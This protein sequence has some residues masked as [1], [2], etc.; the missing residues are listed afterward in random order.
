VSAQSVDNFWQTLRE[1]W[2]Q[3]EYLRLGG[4]VRANLRLNAIRGAARRQPPLNYQLGAGVNFDLLGIQAPFS[5]ALAN[6]NSVYRL[7]RYSFYGVSPAYQWITLHAGDRHL[8]FSPYSLAGINFRGVGFELRPGKFYIGG[9]S[10][11]LRRARFQE[12]GSIQRLETQYQRLGR[13]LKLGYAGETTEVSVAAFYAR[14]RERSVE[15]PVDTLLKPAENLCLDFSL[16]QQFSARLAAEFAITRSAL[17]RD[18]RA[19]VLSGQNVLRRMGGLFDVR[20]TTQF[21]HAYRG[22]IRF[23]PAAGQ[24]RLAFERIDPGYRSLG[25]LFFQNDQENFTVGATVPLFKNRL[26]LNANAGLQRNNLNGRQLAAFNRFVGSLA[27]GWRASERTNVQLN[28]SNFNTTNRVRAISVP[29]VLVDSIVI[30]QSNHAATASASYLLDP[31]GDAVLTASASYQEAAG[32][33]NEA[34]DSTQLNRFGMFLVAYAYQPRESVHRLT[35]SVLATTNRTPV[36]ELWILGP[37]IGYQT[38]LFGERV[39]AGANLALSLVG[40]RT[41]A[42]TAPTVRAQ[43]QASME[44]G[45]HQRLDWQCSYVHV[46]GDVGVRF[47]EVQLGLGYGYT[48]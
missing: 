14:D 15:A 17:T 36:A 33:R 45:E 8:T 5:L 35:A 25:A 16:A 3:G 32:V 22:E 29:F 9:M 31:Q 27:L 40:N 37:S 43:L 47:A 13:G 20:A 12:A 4:S 19:P 42:R 21:A 23:S 41:T 7:P 28:Y 48:F 10:G 1:R 30:V 11:R 34:V 38:R 2:Q 44:L 24:F 39:D 18:H 46:G 26:N 6:G